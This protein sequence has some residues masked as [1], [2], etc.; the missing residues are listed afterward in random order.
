VK[1]MKESLNCTDDK[2]DDGHDKA[3]ENQFFWRVYSSD[4]GRTKATA[5]LLLQEYDVYAN[6]IRNKTTFLQ[7]GYPHDQIQTDTYNIRYDNRLREIA[8][9]LRQ[10]LPKEYTYEE[11]STI[12]KNGQHP[13]YSNNNPNVT[14]TATAIPVLET[15]DDAWNRIYT[16]WLMEVIQD[17]SM[18][19]DETSSTIY[20]V[21]VITHAALLR[22]FLHRLI[23]I[24]KLQQHPEVIYKYDNN[25][26]GIPINNRLHIPNTSCTI[27]NLDIAYHPQQPASSSPI[28]S[29]TAHIQ[30]CDDQRQSQQED[31]DRVPIFRSVEIEQ[32]TSTDHYQYIMQ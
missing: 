10:G 11:A 16:L 2:N 14:D 29:S 32:F 7:Q 25:D 28:L 24:D 15:E 20:N 3:T 19:H 21:L 1:A 30:E 18:L 4:L 13:L 8:R 23:G 27:L 6:S 5:Q 26:S 12:Y 17:I 31:I 9:G 22:V